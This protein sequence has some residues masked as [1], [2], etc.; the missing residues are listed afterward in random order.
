MWGKGKGRGGE[1]GEG[2]GGIIKFT[3][4][5]YASLSIITVK[6]PV[7]SP[8]SNTVGSMDYEEEKGR[9]ELMYTVNR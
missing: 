1:G 9:D 5:Q 3:T 8:P 6:F 2:K 4:V 7:N